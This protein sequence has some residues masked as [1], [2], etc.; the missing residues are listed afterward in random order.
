MCHTLWATDTASFKVVSLWISSFCSIILLLWGCSQKILIWSKINTFI[1]FKIETLTKSCA[2]LTNTSISSKL[3]QPQGE[4]NVF[5]NNKSQWHLW[6][7]EP[8]P[9]NQQATKSPFLIQ[10]IYTKLAF[11]LL[12]STHLHSYLAH[13]SL[14]FFSSSLIFFLVFQFLHQLQNVEGHVTLFQE[15]AVSFRI[16]L[17]I[18]QHVCICW[19]ANVTNKQS[20]S[21]TTVLHLHLYD[22]KLVA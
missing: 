14:H 11:N 22:K 3:Q 17:S 2:Y 20:H 4:W 9:F 19:T 18:H 7:H 21:S 16:D 5:P 10:T 1:L 15:L 6:G 8:L 12:A 13:G